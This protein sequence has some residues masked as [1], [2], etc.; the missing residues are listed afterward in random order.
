M[1][2]VASDHAGYELKRKLKVYLDAKLAEYEDLGP[3]EVIKDDDYPDYCKKVSLRVASA[4]AKALADGQG[5]ADDLGI[6]ICDTGIGMSICA[7]RF[8]GIRAALCT[9]PFMAQRAKEHNDANILVLGAENGDLDR[10]KTIVKAFLESKFTG[11]ERHIRRLSK[12][13][14]L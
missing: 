2:Y 8:K 1:I 11:E 12:I 9:S 6:L 3:D 10:T 13:D 4:D 5:K 14:N 7:N